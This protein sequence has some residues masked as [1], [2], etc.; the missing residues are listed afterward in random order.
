M[1]KILWLL[2]A[3]SI[4]LSGFSRE[5]ILLDGN[6]D[7]PIIGASVISANGMII[8]TTDEN[9]RIAVKSNDYPLS[10]RCMGYEALMQPSQNADT[11]FM[12]PASYALSEV[13]VSPTDRP[14][15]RVVTYAREYCTGSTP[16]D[17]LQFYCEYMLEYY[18][19]DGKVKGYD[20]SHK[21]STTRAVRRYGRIVKANELDTIMRPKY[22]D[23]ITALS[24]MSNMAFV[25]Y[26]RKDLTDAMKAGALADTVQGKYFPKYIYRLNNGYFTIDCDVLSDYKT[27]SFSPWFFKIM[28]MTMDIQ[29]GNWTLIYKQNDG[30]VYGITDFIYSSGNLSILGKGKLLRKM[31]GVSDAIEI[32]CY[33]EQYPVRIER[34][35]VDEYKECKKT[36]YERREVFQIPDNVQ[37]IAPAIQSLLDRVNR[38]LPVKQR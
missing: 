34:L 30:G 29:K 26:E 21:S 16:D 6:D 22:D 31:I 4:A 11:L 13:V 37:P 8:G 10:V 15:T 18:F 28:G 20:K 27:H 25:P 2:L 17:T 3:T 36:Y 24:F 32:N 33:I 1:K 9:G 23:D 14:I 38:E 19:A 35:T 12:H 5:I 7:A